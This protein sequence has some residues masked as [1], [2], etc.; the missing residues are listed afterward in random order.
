MVR[1]GASSQEPDNPNTAPIAIFLNT[2]AT[3][4]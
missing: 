3:C 2:Q 1:S 4:R